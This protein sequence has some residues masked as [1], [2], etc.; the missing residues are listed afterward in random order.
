MV[1][2]RDDNDGTPPP[3]SPWPAIVA[4]TKNPIQL[5]LLSQRVS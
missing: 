4:V 1:A 3:I 2:V 5:L